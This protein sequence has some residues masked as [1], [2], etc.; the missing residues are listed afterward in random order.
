MKEYYKNSQ[1]AKKYGVS[2]PTVGKWLES[3]L[4]GQNNLETIKVNNRFY[5]KNNE[6]NRIELERLRGKGQKYRNKVVYEKIDLNPKFFESYSENQG[7]RVL[8]DLENHG[9]IKFENSLFGGNVDKWAKFSEGVLTKRRSNI[10][11]QT[12]S[13]KKVV[14]SVLPQLEK[15]KKVNIFDFGLDCGIQ[16]KLLL[17]E[18]Q[19]LN[20]NVEYKYVSRE[21]DFFEISRTNLSSS[22]K[23]VKLGYLES[24]IEEE[25]IKKE[26]FFAKEDESVCNLLLF[27]GNTINYH[28]DYLDFLTKISEILT[29]DDFVLFGFRT[30]TGTPDFAIQDVIDD[31]YLAE[32]TA[33][34]TELI[35]FSDDSFVIKDE[36]VDLNGGLERIL[37]LQKDVDINISKNNFQKVIKLKQHDSILVLRYS[38]IDF[39]DLSKDMGDLGYSVVST[40][41]LEDDRIALVLAKLK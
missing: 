8:S 16:V 1:I 4:E 20:I 33:K 26:L 36:M 21:K 9:V 23:E 18:L 39:Y 35:G 12:D 6:N 17:K 30:A 34:T 19:R 11:S 22:S 41:N 32:V 15:Y 37:K 31:E 40:Q 28:E 38:N 29:K 2:R 25:S 3:A 27:L 24:G 5:I 7:A 10:P 13:F 14:S